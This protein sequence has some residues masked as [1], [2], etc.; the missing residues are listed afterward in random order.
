MPAGR[1]AARTTGQALH[2]LKVAPGR[3]VTSPY[4][5]AYE[6]AELV[7]SALS[8]PLA[9]DAAVLGVEAGDVSRA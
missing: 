4:P 6:T 2:A 3:V 8:A 5:R 9:E 1:R 7:A